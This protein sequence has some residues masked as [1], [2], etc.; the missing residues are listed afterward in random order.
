[1]ARAA[2]ELGTWVEDELHMRAHELELE[3]DTLDPPTTEPTEP[4]PPDTDT[5]QMTF[6]E[7]WLYG[8]DLRRRDELAALR[9]GAEPWGRDQ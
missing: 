7:A 9:P 8:S 2:R 5:S 6:E 3:A 4:G 1:M